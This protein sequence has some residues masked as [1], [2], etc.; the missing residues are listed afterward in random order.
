[1]LGCGIAIRSAARPGS[2]DLLAM[3]ALHQRHRMGP[4]ASTLVARSRLRQLRCLHAVV[5]HVG[6][7]GSIAPPDVAS[8]WRSALL[9]SSVVGGPSV[10]SGCPSTLKLKELLIV[11]A[12]RALLIAA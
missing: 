6:Y 4:S 10:P 12:A 11:R 5:R 9:F 1:M 3:G 2:A 8:A 7:A